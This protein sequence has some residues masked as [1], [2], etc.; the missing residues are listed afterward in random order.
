VAFVRENFIVLADD[1]VAYSG[2]PDKHKGE[3]KLMAQMFA[4]AN[5]GIHQGIYTATSAGRMLSR[6]NAGWPDPDPVA[7]LTNLRAAVQRYRSLPAAQRTAQADVPDAE[8]IA[9]ARNVVK[10]PAG[11]LDLRTTVR[12]YAYP[13]MTTFDERHPVF[14]GIDRLW[15]K[16]SEW[17][18]WIPRERR[19]G[20]KVNVDGPLRTRIVMLSHQHKA[21]MAWWEEHIR[22]G[23]MTSTI[24]G[25]QGT[26]MSLRIEADYDMKADSQWNKGSYNGRLLIEADFDEKTQTWTKFQGSMLGTSNVGVRLSNVHAGDLTQQVA[27]AITLN[28]LSDP[29]EALLPMH[30]PDYYGRDW[31]ASP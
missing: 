3:Y 11:T 15:F 1:D 30:W 8:R 5:T 16:P 21:S 18:G 4:G 19:V 25:L 17:C 31:A 22:G 29:D 23:R 24:T 7:T 2:A 28:P 6:A 10:K 9:R 20:A 26:V 13:G 14:L 12:G 27:T